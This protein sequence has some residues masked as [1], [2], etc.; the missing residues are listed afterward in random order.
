MAPRRACIRTWA[1]RDQ[2]I[3]AT[4]LNFSN[5]TRELH[6]WNIFSAHDRA[7]RSQEFVGRTNVYEA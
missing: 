6:D 7:E 2:Q 5:L 1:Y 3:L 4:L